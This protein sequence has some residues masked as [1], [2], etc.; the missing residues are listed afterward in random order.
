MQG[1]QVA[2]KEL[3]CSSGR[4][5]VSDVGFPPCQ[6]VD[7]PCV[8]GSVQGNALPHSLC[9]RGQLP[10]CPVQPDVDH[11]IPDPHRA[12]DPEAFDPCQLVE[13]ASASSEEPHLPRVVLLRAQFGGS[14]VLP[15][16]DVVELFPGDLVPGG[17]GASLAG[18]AHAGDV[19]AGEV[20]IWNVLDRLTGY[21]C[22]DCVQCKIVYIQTNA[23][24]LRIPRKNLGRLC[25]SLIKAKRT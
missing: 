23:V 10:H 15:C 3:T 18:N 20:C 1:F 22:K 7:Q 11:G 19:V 4:T 21:L 13:D 8:Q 24:S 12:G 16:D 25:Y 9:Q 14:L 6:P 17:E 5:D 2:V